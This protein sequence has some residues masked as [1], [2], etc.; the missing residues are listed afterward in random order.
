MSSTKGPIAM[1]HVLNSPAQ[2]ARSIAS[3]ICAVALAVVLA[4]CGSDD[5]NTK[6]DASGK[7]PASSAGAGT[8]GGTGA[9]VDQPDGAKPLKADANSAWPKLEVGQ[10]VDKIAQ[11]KFAKVSCTGPHEGEVAGVDTAM[12]DTLVPSGMAFNKYLNDKCEELVRPKLDKQSNAADF[13]VQKLGP[14]VTTWTEGKDRRLT[15]IVTR[16]NQA[17]LTAPLA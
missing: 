4:G 10:C 8:K 9:P 7:N 1:L 12:P 14:S 3:A 6:D 17:P 5:D 15:C 2:N 11:P 13:V 16:K